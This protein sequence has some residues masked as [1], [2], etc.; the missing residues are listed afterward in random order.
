MNID[1]VSEI[2]GLSKSKIR[3]YEE[4]DLIKVQRK[5]NG[6]RDFKEEDIQILKIINDLKRLNLKLKDI[7][8]IILLFQKP[9]TQSCNDESQIFLDNIIQIIKDNIDEQIQI[10]KRVEKI[11]IMSENMKYEEN[12]SKILNELSGWKENI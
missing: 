5:E 9:V 2:S 8:Y 4:M 3:Y 10:L 7:E 6:Y 1:K 12:K 11:K